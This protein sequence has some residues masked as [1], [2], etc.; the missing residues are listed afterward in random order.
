MKVATFLKQVSA[1]VSQ[2]ATEDQA[3]DHSAQSNLRRDPFDLNITEED[4]TPGQVE[5]ILDYAKPNVS[6]VIKG[7]NSPS[8]AIKLFKQNPS[9]LNR[10]LVRLLAPFPLSLGSPQQHNNELTYPKIVDWNNGKV[11]AG[12]EESAILKLLNALPPKN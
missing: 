1:S 5:T 11:Y 4:P 7:A 2:T 6:S 3:S 12:T 10:P 8:E 9:T